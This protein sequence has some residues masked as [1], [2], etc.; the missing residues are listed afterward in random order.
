MRKFQVTSPISLLIP[1]YLGGEQKE[2]VYRDKHVSFKRDFQKV[3][4]VDKEDGWYDYNLREKKN[5]IEFYPSNL[6]PFFTR[7]YDSL[8]HLKSERVYSKIKSFGV[9]GF[10]GGIPTSMHQNTGQQVGF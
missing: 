2:Q 3:F 7:C 10:D 6:A 5:N 4:W 8:D 1:L 9:F